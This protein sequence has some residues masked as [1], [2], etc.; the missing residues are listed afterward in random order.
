VA[1]GLTVGAPADMVLFD[2][3]GSRI[4]VLTTIKAGQVS[5]RTTGMR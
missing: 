4:T 2:W 5:Y 1:Q 3:D